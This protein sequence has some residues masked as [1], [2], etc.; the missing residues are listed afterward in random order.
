MAASAYEDEAGEARVESV[1]KESFGQSCT[2]QTG[3][4]RVF[5]NFGAHIRR[6]RNTEFDVKVFAVSLGVERQF[7]L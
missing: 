6:S 3:S 7:T 4:D 1:K 2:D 5:L